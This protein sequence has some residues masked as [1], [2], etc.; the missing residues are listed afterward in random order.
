MAEYETIN[1]DVSDGVATVTLNRP[2]AM[3]SLST[4][5]VRELV[6]AV[7]TVEQD[8]AIRALIVTGTGRAFCCGADL[9]GV[10]SELLS[11]DT[12]GFTGF[13]GSIQDVFVQIREMPK[14]TI[15]ALN[16]LT[17]AGGLE[18]AISCDIVLAARSARLGDSHSNF[19]V[20]P[21]GGCG[22]IL[23]R[24]I[25]EKKA[26]LLLFSGDNWSAE[27][28]EK[29][30]FVSTVHDDDA[31]LGEAKKLASRLVQKSP[32]VLAKMKE[33]VEQGAQ[34]NTRSALA[35]ESRLLAEHAKSADFLEGLS[36]F[37][38]KRTPKY[39]GK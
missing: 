12:D 31:L 35:L 16:G 13:L 20:L 10:L 36:A 38:E 1:F 11:G 23:P 39:T 4:T 27:E 24:Y 25:G 15:A 2:D 19:G 32:L 33:M 8:D 7:S 3:N 9:K 34:L 26:N 21:G 22:T 18:M 29:L 14:P 28:F 17:L 30:G 6:Q 5:M 37:S